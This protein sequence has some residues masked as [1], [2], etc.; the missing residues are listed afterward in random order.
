LAKSREQQTWSQEG[1]WAV[2]LWARRT[3]PQAAWPWP[4]E[5][6]PASGMSPRSPAARGRRRPRARRTAPRGHT[7]ALVG[8]RDAHRSEAAAVLRSE[9]PF[10]RSRRTMPTRPRSSSPAR[11]GEVQPWPPASKQS[12]TSLQICAITRPGLHARRGAPPLAGPIVGCPLRVRL[13]G[14]C[15][16]EEQ[17]RHDVA[18]ASPLQNSSE[19][20][21]LRSVL[22]NCRR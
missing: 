7:G 11:M 8:G 18:G 13:G 1:A 3:A 9:R 17:P 4:G 5:L 22:G 10:A 6:A 16:S 20:P 19:F 21:Q 12:S 2:A 14:P 15:Q